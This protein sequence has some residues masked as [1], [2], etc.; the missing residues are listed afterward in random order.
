MK[1]D[2]KLGKPF[3]S[4]DP[5]RHGAY[6]IP[7]NVVGAGLMPAAELI[8]TLKKPMGMRTIEQ[9]ILTELSALIQVELYGRV[10]SNETPDKGAKDERLLSGVQTDPSGGEG[11]KSGS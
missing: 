8:E 5:A 2:F 1:I 3:E 10:L 6:V 11:Q 9:Q 7:F 4:G